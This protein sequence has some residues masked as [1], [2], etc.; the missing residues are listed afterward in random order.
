MSVTGKLLTV[1]ANIAKV[2]DEIKRLTER[3]SSATTMF[4]AVHLLGAAGAEAFCSRSI[5]GRSA[6]DGRRRAA[7]L[8]L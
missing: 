2:K 3:C 6:Y 1:L 7:Q 5:F 8:R 4:A